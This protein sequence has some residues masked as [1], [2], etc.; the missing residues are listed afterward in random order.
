MGYD[1]E[2]TDE[3]WREE[4][5]PMEYA[6][7]REAGTERAFVGRLTDTETVGVYRCKACDAKLFESETK[8]HSGCGW[9]SF[10]QAVPD[11]VEEREDNSHGMRR[12]EVLCR[13]CGSHL[14]HVFPDGYGTPTGDMK[15]RLQ[16][17]IGFHERPGYADDQAASR[18]R[19]EPQ[20]LEP[21]GAALDAGG[22]LPR[23]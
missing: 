13:S 21:Y 16:K 14:G 8:F 7:L 15:R 19:E 3:Q 10:Y 2:K 4:L 9:P 1:V 17:M 6:V 18:R 20:A 5:S 22:P 23:S 11:T 12:V